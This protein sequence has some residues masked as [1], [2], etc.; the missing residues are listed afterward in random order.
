MSSEQMSLE[1]MSLEQ[2]SLVQMSL[3]Q[4]SLEQMSLEQMSLEQNK[5]VGARFFQKTLKVLQLRLNR[6]SVTPILSWGGGEASPRSFL[7]IVA[8]SV[9]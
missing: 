1:Q 4:M 7:S 5:S 9:D 3:E 6:K 2:M 8:R